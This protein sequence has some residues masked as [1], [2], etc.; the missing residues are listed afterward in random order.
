MNDG[1]SLLGSQ[2]EAE[3]ASEVQRKSGLESRGLSIVTANLG[4]PTLYFALRTQLLRSN[5]GL[6]R[7]ILYSATTLAVVSI[8]LALLSATPRYYRGTKVDALRKSVAILGKM[9]PN[10]DDSTATLQQNILRAKL[11]QLTVARAAN[12]SKAIMLSGAFAA[13]GVAIAMFVI[14]LCTS[15]K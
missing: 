1:L 12:R 2:I 14:A 3:L 4:I 5:H 13:L 7:Y 9:A 8:V 15:S 6:S 10:A 11:S